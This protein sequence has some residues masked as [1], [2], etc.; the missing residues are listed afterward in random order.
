MKFCEENKAFSFQS[1]AVH[2]MDSSI[3]GRNPEVAV[4]P[5]LK[6][7]CKAA[8][9]QRKPSVECCHRWVGKQGHTA[10]TQLL[11]HSQSQCQ[12]EQCLCSG[13]VGIGAASDPILWPL[14]R[15]WSTFKRDWSSAGSLDISN[16]IQA[17]FQ[18]TSGGLL[19]WRHQFWCSRALGSA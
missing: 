4:C 11:P 8:A 12:P 13:L 17:N 15:K 3:A 14:E 5:K 9:K 6:A 10:S 2:E 18:Y 19:S 16:S 1:P 7:S